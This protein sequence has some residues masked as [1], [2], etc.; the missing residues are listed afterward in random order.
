MSGQLNNSN[1]R[2]YAHPTH[3]EQYSGISQMWDGSMNNA[4]QSSAS[5]SI[6]FPKKAQK[7]NQGMHSQHQE[8]HKSTPGQHIIPSMSQMGDNTK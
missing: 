2:E 3:Q 4:K 5:L 8:D 7:D 1:R 6:F